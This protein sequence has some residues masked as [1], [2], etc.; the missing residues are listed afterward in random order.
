MKRQKLGGDGDLVDE[1]GEIGGKLKVDGGKNSTHIPARKT[2]ISLRSP[3]AKPYFLTFKETLF[4]PHPPLRQLHAVTRS[5]P[6]ET[7][8]KPPHPA[9]PARHRLIL[10]LASTGFGIK[11]SGSASESRTSTLLRFTCVKFS[12]T[13]NLSTIA[14]DSTIADNSGLKRNPLGRLSNS[15]KEFVRIDL[16]GR[17]I[18]VRNLWKSSWEDVKFVRSSRL[19]DLLG[20]KGDNQPVQEEGRYR[21]HKS[22]RSTSDLRHH[23]DL[24]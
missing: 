3:L 8:N 23:G 16:G 12:G 7:L 20:K 1:S 18:P 9:P 15:C 19:I 5:T 13:T 22:F 21:K 2:P 10:P 11:H 4:P 6:R 17:H 14:E 24:E